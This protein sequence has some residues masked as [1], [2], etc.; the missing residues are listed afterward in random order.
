VKRSYD[1]YCGLAKALDLVGGRWTPLL[2]RELIPGPRRFR[3]LMD[4]LPGIGTN[5]LADRLR[6]LQDGGVV[7]KRTLPPPAGS[8]VYDLT[9]RGRELVPIL[10]GLARWGFA[11]TGPL[12]ER[13]EFRVHWLMIVREGAFRPEAGRGE[14]ITCEMRTSESDVA[15]FRIDDGAFE[16]LHGPADDPDL[17]LSGEPRTLVDLFEGAVPPEEAIANGVELEGDPG[18]LRRLLAMFDPPA[19]DRDDA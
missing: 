4:G 16:I 17:S 12:G 13:D 18:A 10:G 7:V 14:R 3:D 6:Q 15:H 5:L 1:Q 8:T 9:E 2:I 19:A 11:T